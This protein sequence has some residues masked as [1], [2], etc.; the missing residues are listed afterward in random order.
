M[1]VQITAIGAQADGKVIFAGDFNRVNGVPRVSIARV[2]ADGSLDTTFNPGTGFNGTISKIVVQSDGKILVGGD[3]FSYN[4]TPRRGIA[5]LNADGSLDTNFNPITPSNTFLTV[6]TIALQSDGKI[7]IGGTFGSVNGQTRTSIARLNADG[8]LDTSFNPTFGNA[9]IRSIVV[10]SDGKI[11]VGG[12]FSGVNGFSRTN[13]VRLNA[14]GSLDSSFNTGNISEVR[15]IEV[16]TDGR[17][18]ILTNTIVR[19]N[20]NGATDS[21][22]VSPTFNDTLNQFLVQPDGSILVGGRFTAINNVSRSNIARLQPNGAL[23]IGFLPSGANGA[24]RT[25]CQTSRRTEF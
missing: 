14:D 5:R 13:L 10:Q 3:I 25:I 8:S 2:N 23:D 12:F 18:L 20:N 19:L 22:F 1:P 21:T 9:T 16:Q 11:M 7:L 6:N 17:Y 15:Q 4:G 24:V